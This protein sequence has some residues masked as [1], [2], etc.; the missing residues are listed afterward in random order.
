MNKKFVLATSLL[1]AV[2]MSTNSQAFEFG[3]PVTTAVVV[4]N[5]G[6]QLA[7]IS[8]Q[9]TPGNDAGGIVA[10]SGDGGNRRRQ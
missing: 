3:N 2:I 10:P 6:Q 1:T 9:V 4:T 7:G 5:P 8:A